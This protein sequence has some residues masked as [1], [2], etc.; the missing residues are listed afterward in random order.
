MAW[1]YSFGGRNDVTPGMIRPSD[2]FDGEL[3]VSIDK[4]PRTMRWRAR[5]SMKMRG[6][7]N[8]HS[9][10]GDRY[11][12]FLTMDWGYEQALKCD[13]PAVEKTLVERLEAMS[14][15]ERRLSVSDLCESVYSLNVSL[16]IVK[17][18]TQRD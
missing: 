9:D 16:G 4:L 14:A 13:D 11:S 1:S 12:S 7:A 18:N 2:R 6:R 10:D 5:R 15:S 8:E 3:A 17:R